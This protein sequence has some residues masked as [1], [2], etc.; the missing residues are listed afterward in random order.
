MNR[1]K[2]SEVAETQAYI[3][4]YHRR[5]NATSSNERTSS[6]TPNGSED[7]P[8]T[9]HGDFRSMRKSVV[10]HLEAATDQDETFNNS[11]YVDIVVNED[12][13][14]SQSTSDSSLANGEILLEDVLD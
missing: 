8:D 4:F 6:I 11:S 7:A 12:G 13:N 3:L 10:T 2:D 5:K 9:D 1:V 14:N